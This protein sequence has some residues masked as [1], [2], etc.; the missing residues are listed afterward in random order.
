MD[1][2]ID[3]YS[4]SAASY[5]WLADGLGIGAPDAPIEQ[6]WARVRDRMRRSSEQIVVFATDWISDPWLVP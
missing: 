4:E 5:R 3:E 2:Y 1:K 6:E